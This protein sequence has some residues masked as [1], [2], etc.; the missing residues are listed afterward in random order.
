MNEYDELL[1]S[2]GGDKANEYDAAIADDEQARRSGLRQS[3]YVATRSNPDKFAEAKKLGTITGVPSDVAE[4]NLDQVKENAK[5]NEYDN[6]VTQSP[7][8]AQ[9]LTNT[10]LAKLAHDDVANMGLLESTINSFKRGIPGLKQMFEA[11]Q[12]ANKAFGISNFREIDT[13]LASGEDFKKVMYDNNLAGATPEMYE[14]IKQERIGIYQKGIGESAVEI[15][16]LQEE[17]QSFPQPPIVEQ[18]MRA[19]TFGEATKLIMSDPLQFL[20]SIGPESMVQSAPGM[21]L[22]VPAGLTMGPLGVAGTIGTN[23]FLTDY[24]SSLLEALQDEGVN[25]GDPKAMQTASQNPEMMKRVTDRALKH[26]QVVAAFD[27]LSGGIASKVTLPKSIATKLAGKPLAQEAASM[28][29][30]MPVQASLGA[31]GEAG[32]EVYSGQPLQPGNILAEAAGEFAGAPI[33]VLT[34]STSRI[35]DKIANAMQSKQDVEVIQQLNELA[36]NSKLR[37]RDPQSFQKFIEAAAEDGPVSDVYVNPVVLGDLLNQSG[38]DPSTLP[39]LAEQ[40][41]EATLTNTDVKIPIDVYA[42]HIAGTEAAPALLQHIKTAPD[43]M[44]LQEQQQFFQSSAEEFKAEAEKIL[45]ATQENQALVQSA[46]YIEDQMMQQL[47]EANRFTPDVNQ[48]YASL[49]RD[50]YVVNAEKLGISPQQ[51]FEKYPLQ[52]RAQD[53]TGDRKLDQSQFKST[54]TSELPL[55]DDNSSAYNIGTGESNNGQ[56]TAN[57]AGSGNAQSDQIVPRNSRVGYSQQ[58]WS[59]VTRI[60]GKSGQPL[61]VFRG[62]TEPRTSIDF[63]RIGESTGHASAHIGAFFTA[64]QEDAG[65][66][67]PAVSPFYLDLRNPAVYNVE[68]LPGF[69]TPQ[70]AKSFRNKLIEAGHDGLIIRAD[71]LGG[72]IQF[73][74]FQ[75][76][77]IVSQEA[78]QSDIGNFEELNQPAFHGSPHDFENFSTDNIGTGEG[79]QAFGWGLYFAENPSIAKDYQRTLGRNVIYINGEPATDLNRATPE[80]AAI[81]NIANQGLENSL[82]ALPDLREQRGIDLQWVDKYEAAL[83]SHADDKIESRS[84]GRLYEVDIPDEAVANMLDWDKPI[85]EQP[86]VLDKLIQASREANTLGDETIGDILDDA[87]RDSYRDESF[88]GIEPVDKETLTGAILYDKLTYALDDNKENASKYLASIGIPGNKYLD[89]NSRGFTVELYTDEDFK[90]LYA[91]NKFN[92]RQSAEEYAAEKRAEGFTTSVETNEGTRNLVVFDDKIITLTHK[93]GSPVSKQERKEYFQSEDLEQKT[94]KGKRGSIVIGKDITTTPSVITLL[95]DA[96]LSTFLHESGHF[97]LEVMQNMSSAENAPQE[98]KDDFDSIIKWFG[99]KDAETWDKMKFEDK[100]K[101]HEQFARGFEAYLFS[102]ESPN[103]EMQNVFA[104]FRAWLI[105][106]YKS[107]RQLNVNLTPEVTGVFDRMIATNDQ[108]REAQAARS[109]APLFTSPEQA[110]M[111]VEEWRAYQKTNSDATNEAVDNLQTRS[112]RNMQWF[113]NAHSRELGRLQRDAREKR[114][115]MRREVATEVMNEPIN[116][117]RQFIQ[118]GTLEETNHNNEQRRLLEDIGMTGSKLS[119]K[120][121]KEMYGDDPAAPWRYLPVGKYGLAANEGI[122]PNIVAELFGFSSGDELVRA[123]IDAEPMRE[124]I[125]GLTDQRMLERYG[126]IQDPETMA[127]AAD[128]A[129]HNK[130]R[131]KVITTELNSLSKAAGQRKV[132]N[133]A[134]QQ[135][136]AAIVARKRVRDI[137]PSQYSAAETR[138]ARAAQDALKKADLVTAAAEKKNQLVNYYA[139]KAAHEAIDEVGKTVKYLSKFDSETTR[140]SLDGSYLEQIDA[141]LEHYDLRKGIS[142]KE[143]DKRKSLPQWVESQRELGFEPIVDPELLNDAN[144]KHFKDMTLEEMRGLSDAVKNIEHL[145]RLKKKLLTAKDKKEFDELVGSISQSITDNAKKTIDQKL[146]SNTFKDRAG[147]GINEFFAMHRK[148]ASMVQEMDG[149]KDAG[150]FWNNF[151]RPMNEA[152]DN[153]A[154]MREAATIKLNELF[155][156]LMKE[157][158]SK[159]VYIPAINASLSREGRLMVALNWGNEGNRQRLLDGDKWNPTQVQAVLD[160]LSQEEWQFVQGIWDYFETFRSE[161]GAQQKR[162]TGLEPEWVQATPIQT[163]Y[164]EFRGGYMPAKYDTDR[165]TRSLS[166]EA[167]AGIMEQWRAAKGRAKTRD[168]FTQARAEKVVDRPLRKDFGVLFQHVTEVTHRLAWQEWVVDANRLLRAQGVDQAIR[169]H[170]GPET[171]NAVRKGV[172]DIAA[173]ETPA[174]NTFEASINYLRSGATIAGLGWNVVTSLLQ[175]LGLTQSMVRIGPKWVAKGLANW[176]GS[177]A[178]MSAAVDAIYGKSD[179]MRLRGKTMQREISEIR[180]KVSAGSP[181]KQAIEGSYFYLIQKMQQVADIPTWLGQYEKAIAEGH[182][183]D[184]AVALADQAVLD[185]Q[186]GGQVKDL[187]AIQRGGPLMKLWTNFYSFFNTTY[188]LTARSIN[189]TDFKNPASVAMLGVDFMLLYIL[190]AFLASTMKA[191]L[192][193]EIGD[194]KFMEKVLRDQLNYL[195]GTMVGLRELGTLVN[196]FAGYDGP[197]GIRIFSEIAKLGKQAEQGDLDVAL[198]KAVNN[199]AGILFHYP[200]GQIQKTTEGI[201]HLSEGKSDNPAVLLVGPPS[202]K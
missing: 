72:P 172:E 65:R 114:K 136:A 143:I 81:S 107:I 44:T 155:K 200:A 122:S 144:K 5:L 83:K 70:E 171:L 23:S 115:A 35:K 149:N 47:K 173:G 94:G 2:T 69:D 46:K 118:H 148:L 113:D 90:E 120:D 108:I 41:S 16:K 158:F 64:S 21:V 84:S 51:M 93:D 26:A 39:N 188:N 124:K 151:I 30:Q 17:K 60:R 167:A 53:V 112:L 184:K 121:L 197:A 199:V 14:K 11:T 132:L 140:K 98:I 68:D 123:L 12:V 175:P 152:G 198:M 9:Q 66:Y 165:S 177:P 67:G 150:V 38:I 92:N 101:Y 138:A 80:G 105:Q 29:V 131:A 32:G 48:A 45:A 129:I 135:Y 100:R 55:A 133:K 160:T 139:T 27:A 13:R 58:G 154:T 6:L 61:T 116:Q 170:Y 186:G 193:G 192:K 178:K 37:Q 153:E 62:D 202:K 119:L 181:T 145:G 163:R 191:A 82:S 134:A 25:I 185:A 103:I 99:I 180:N 196:G 78:G 117:A 97:F 7:V 89:S 102:G 75:P 183:E 147:K 176:L 169:N 182:D 168:S 73:V 1:S 141:L 18:V 110:G 40:I 49:I 109:Y 111:T 189:R 74:A 104:R 63:G 50:F 4:R 31:A 142:Q 91:S 76:D 146:E 36:A 59:S 52:V 24:G 95:K 166:D 126:D 159:K 190:P 79:N 137:K 161:I 125:E 187:A 157:G 87:E 42:T 56:S 10:E 179:F 174:Q 57:N 19:K 8:T 77:Q 130:M 34:A 106:V 128:A 96:D 194:D 201:V 195:F 33:E 156:P 162:L 43:S 22:S 15:A 3:L 85:S 164:G 127:R 20:G 86:E 88:G 71:H 28:A 54:L